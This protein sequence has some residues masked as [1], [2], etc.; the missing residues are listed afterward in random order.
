MARGKSV[1]GYQ[2]GSLVGFKLTKEDQDLIPYLNE[3]KAAGEE[4]SGLLR[5]IL[6][7]HVRRQ[8]DPAP[9]QLDPEQLAGWVGNLIR[10]AMTGEGEEQQLTPAEVRAVAR[11]ADEIDSHADAVQLVRK[12]LGSQFADDDED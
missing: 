6:R 2:V 8:T 1:E 4:M 11:V 12:K 5:G 9:P 3:R 7:E 10:R